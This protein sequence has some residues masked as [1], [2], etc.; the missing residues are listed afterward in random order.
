M[1][2]FAGLR[3]HLG[4][5]AADQPVEEEA[6]QDLIE[7][8]ADEF[9]GTDRVGRCAGESLRVLRFGSR[10]TALAIAARPI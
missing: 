2:F 7:P 4:A 3:A 10:G 5:L 6:D 1:G 8:L 9:L